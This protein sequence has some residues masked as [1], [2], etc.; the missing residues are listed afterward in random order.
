MREMWG[1]SQTVRE[2]VSGKDEGGR[3]KNENATAAHS[4]VNAPGH[5]Q[6]FIRAE[7]HAS[8]DVLSALDD[9]AESHVVDDDGV[10]P[11]DVERALSRRRHRE[12]VGFSLAAFQK[13]PDHTDRLTA[14]IVRCVD[15][16][17]C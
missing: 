14:V 11:F 12:E 16:R 7:V 8:E 15:F 2:G 3:M 4:T 6:D 9:V 1:S 5:L 17:K 10:E 13:R